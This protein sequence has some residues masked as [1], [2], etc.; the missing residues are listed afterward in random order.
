ME[1]VDR[2][3]YCSFH[4]YSD[5]PQSIGFNA[6][7]SAPHMHAYCLE[8]MG[9]HLKP[10][11]RVLDVGCGSGYLTACFAKMV[12]KQGRVIGMEHLQG[13]VDL[14]INNIQKSNGDML[15]SNVK[16]VL[17]D[18]RCGVKGEIF[19][20]IHVGAA[21][22]AIPFALVDQLAMPGRLVMYKVFN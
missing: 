19:D 15:E 8:L 1:S 16:I 7:I 6:T 2:Q 13:L 20:A 17:G 22:P 21:S 4:P 18:G 10:G 9:D 12:G 11:S 5:T 14:S 3:D